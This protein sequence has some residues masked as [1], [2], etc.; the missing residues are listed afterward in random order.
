MRVTKPGDTRMGF[1]GKWACNRCGCEWEMEATDPKPKQ[2][3][4]QRDGDAFHMPCPTCK[5]EVYRDIPRR[6]DYYRYP[7]SNQAIQSPDADG[8]LITEQ[9]V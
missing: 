1:E 8:C 3:T 4:D 7:H 6:Q 9:G 5:E 2:S